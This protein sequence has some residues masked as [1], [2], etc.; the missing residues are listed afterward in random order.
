MKIFVNGDALS[1]SLEKENS[2][3]DIYQALSGWAA[4]QGARITGL[5]LDGRNV[6][7]LRPEEWGEVPLQ[8]VQ[9]LSLTAVSE[10]EAQG[11]GLS[12]IREYLEVLGRALEAGDDEAGREV[13]KEY[14]YIRRGLEIHLKDIFSNA[15]GKV[16][17]ADGLLLAR[18]DDE[19]FTQAE[20]EAMRSYVR[21]LSVIVQ[22]RLQEI[23]EPE[24]EAAAVARLLL[25][26]KPA[27]ENVPVLLQSGKDREAMQNILSYTELAL[28]AVRILSQRSGGQ[29]DS[30]EFCKELNGVLND[31]TSAF[32]ARDSVLIGDLFEY[33]IAPRT[34]R[35][36]ELLERGRA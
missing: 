26:A 3:F 18:R 13:L 30:R 22:D 29:E 16:F 32:E 36:A 21:A 23:K 31:L 17:E 34:D 35:L 4:S 8:S 7:I 10:E 20:K 1:F 6:D 9:Q 28:K 5:E 12:V 24:K 33:E 15:G 19:P 11:Y 25:G 2:L 14:P 27:L